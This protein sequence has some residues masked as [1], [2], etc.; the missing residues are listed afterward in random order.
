M[1]I[2][3]LDENKIEQI[4]GMSVDYPYCMHK[5]N[6]TDIVIPWHWHEELE[7]GYLEKGTSI[8]ST[9]NAEY[10]IHQGDGFFINTNVMDTKRNAVPGH[11]A[12]EINHIFHPVFLSGHFKSRFESKYLNPIL[13]NRQIEV[14]II[15][16]GTS[17]G[18]AIL[19]NLIKLKELQENPDV[20]IQ[21][22]NLLSETWLLL[23]EE[24]HT[25]FH[26]TVCPSES[27]NRLRNMLLFI[28]T[29]YAE[30]ITLQEIASN[31]SL[32]AREAQRCFQRILHQSPSE[33]LISY[34]LN[35]AKKMLLETNDSITEIAFLCGFSD[36]SYFSKIFRKKSGFTPMEYRKKIFDS[37]SSKKI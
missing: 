2:L 29:H 13:K 1:D 5:R 7:L 20:E 4:E 9:V 34:R 15:R 16:H 30:K 11:A 33:Y 3:H 28:H 27:E 36:A 24:L 18:N 19:S 23:R 25:N 12:L 32:S 10:T 26:E 17:S 35:H 37:H 22:R 14:H 8:I 6:L 21:T 31:A